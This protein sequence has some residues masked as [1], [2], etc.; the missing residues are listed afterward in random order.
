VLLEALEAQEA[1]KR[2]G[3]RAPGSAARK[4]KRRVLTR[5]R[6]S[7]AQKRSGS[8]E[9]QRKR[10][11]KYVIPMR[12]EV[13][14]SSSGFFLMPQ[15]DQGTIQ[16]NLRFGTFCAQARYLRALDP[17]SGCIPAPRNVKTMSIV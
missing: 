2:C 12:S 16:M 13:N 15:S 11:A 6:A 7:E 8:A 5:A 9:A 17:S 10:R 4:Q 14:L 1:Q 3:A